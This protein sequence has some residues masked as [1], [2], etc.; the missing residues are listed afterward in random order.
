MSWK[1]ANNSPPGAPRSWSIT[2]RLALLYALTAFGLLLFSTS[3]LYWTLARYLERK[4]QQFLFSEVDILSEILMQRPNE[5]RVEL[6]DREIHQGV[7]EGHFARYYIRLS[8]PDGRVF[9]AT[10]GMENRLPSDCFPSLT[11]SPPSVLVARYTTPEKVPYLLATGINSASSSNKNQYVIQVALDISPENTL[12]A[13]YRRNAFMVLLLG[14]VVPSVAALGMIRQGLKP[15]KQIERS[16]ARIRAAHLHERLGAGG[17]PREIVPLVEAFDEMLNRLEASFARLSRFSADLAHELRTP[18][19]N[20]RGEA[21]VALSRS[22]TPDEY[23][24]VIESSMEEYQRLSRLI[25]NLLFISRSDNRGTSIRKARLDVAGEVAA[26]REF[27]LPWADEHGV[28]VSVRGQA[29]LAADSLLFRRAVSNLLANALQ[30]TPSGGRI[31]VEIASLPDGAVDVTV[32]DSGVGISA[33]DLPRVFDRFYRADGARGLYPQGM[34][35]G[36]SI[37]RSIM[38]LHG[39]TISV[40][41]DPGRGT[42]LTLHFPP[43]PEIPPS[44]R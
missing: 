33:E 32:S 10:P 27:Y 2:A 3:F 29:H 35:L 40:R 42:S 16:V 43:S 1:N 5:D 28:D 15:L 23:R 31:T 20:L 25:D 22:R 7:D 6:L 24:Q 36:L 37:V 19:N 8:D 18:I 4:N 41:S 12:L 21:E 9:L 30:Y 13:D 44:D 17:W 38:S 39:G 14:I 11:G 26:V 34:G